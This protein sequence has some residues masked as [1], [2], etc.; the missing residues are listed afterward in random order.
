MTGC[1]KVAYSVERKQAVDKI[2]ELFPGLQSVQIP[3]LY[4]MF[5]GNPSPYPFSKHFDDVKNEVAFI[6]HSS[7]TTGKHR[8]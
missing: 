8:L 5:E 4:E 1:T 7:G 6:G 3:S 2:Q